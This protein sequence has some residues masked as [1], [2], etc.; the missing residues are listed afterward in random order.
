LRW[1]PVGTEP[2]SEWAGGLINFQGATTSDASGAAGPKRLRHD[3]RAQEA[4]VV[5]RCLRGPAGT[6][7]ERP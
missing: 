3:A 4:L 5:R 7:R 2:A 6:E 1:D